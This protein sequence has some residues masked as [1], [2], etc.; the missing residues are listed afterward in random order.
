MERRR[1]LHLAATAG[2][3]VSLANPF[4]LARSQPAPDQPNVLFIIVEDLNDWVGPLGGHPNTLTP[5]LDAFAQTAVN[6]TNAF[7]CAAA[8]NPSRTSIFTG[9]LPSSSGVYYNSQHWQIQL[10]SAY[11]TLPDRFHEAEYT[12]LLVGKFYHGIVD[13]PVWDLQFPTF[14]Y[15]NMNGDDPYL[16]GHPYNGLNQ[17]WQRGMSND[18]LWGGSDNPEGSFQD[19]LRSRFV[20]NRLNT[21][22]PEPFFIALGTRAAHLPWTPPRRFLEKFNPA[23]I[24]LPPFLGSDL[25]DIPR[26][27]INLIKPGLHHQVVQGRQWH[28]AVLNYLATINYVDEQIGRVLDALDNSPY[29]DNTV[30][31]ITSDHGHHLGEKYHWRKWTMWDES[32]HVPLLIRAPGVSAAGSVCRHTVSLVDLYPTLIDLCGLDE[33]PDLDGQSLRPQLMDGHTPT[34]RPAVSSNSPT[35]HTVRSN[36]Y[37]YIYYGRE[38]GEELYDCWRDPNEWTNLASDPGHINVKRELRGWIPGAVDH[39]DR[40]GR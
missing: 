4:R 22:L 10:G 14:D 24:E 18:M 29:A 33:V 26:G 40:W 9:L 8:C 12:N 7:S 19:V 25:N 32:L 11:P 16:P 15:H 34:N 38:N 23:E 6:F 31:I 21:D 39:N 35:E 36:R 30:V 1:F 28:L 17:S 5:N 37:R 2:A 3:G 20:A 13:E 27:G